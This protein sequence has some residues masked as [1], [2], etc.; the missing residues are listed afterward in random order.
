M[1]I[2]ELTK[3]KNDAVQAA[4]EL[5]NRADGESRSMTD[6]ESTNFDKA[7][8]DSERY[9]ADI[10]KRSRLDALEAQQNESRGRIT[11]PET[12]TSD[13][14]LRDWMLHGTDAL[15]IS[16]RNDPLRTDLDYDKWQTRALSAGT[17]TAGAE[18]VP[19]GFAGQIERAMLAYGGV[20]EGASVI[21][22]STGNDLPWPTSDDTDNVGAILAEN[23]ADSEQDVEFGSVTLKAY[24]YTSKIVRV[25]TELIQDAG[26]DIGSLLADMLGER[27]ARGTA[28]HF[29]TG[30][31]T[32]QP[33]GLITGS[34][35]AFT[36]SSATTFT[37]DELINLTFS[38]DE[39]YRRKAKFILSPSA[40][41]VI[42]K[43]KDD[44]GQPLWR[45]VVAGAPN[46]ILGYNYIVCPELDS[47]AATKKPIAFG[48]LSKYRIRDVRDVQ[49]ARLQERYA[50]YHQIGF[51]AISRHDGRMVDA[52]GAA[53]KYITMKSS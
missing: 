1:T 40:L 53:I 37:L 24:K 13:T 30:T 49:V 47:V 51:V 16:L 27:I 14:G 5:L 19:E 12:R 17:A 18:L 9:A 36:S 20:R 28:V 35:S 6:E 25:S 31:G 52:S 34:T 29:A 11:R 46:T 3:R 4:R 2:A 33:Q 39:E 22:T 43:M 21:R 48:D 45:P 10:D 26:V 41:S 8:A 50:E 42:S 15:N 38:V 32:N 7:I 44:N 23:A